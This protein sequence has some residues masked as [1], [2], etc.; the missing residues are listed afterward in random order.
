MLVLSRAILAALLLPAIGSAQTDPDNV[1]QPPSTELARLSP[2][3]GSYSVTSEYVDQEWF[4][5]LD[6]RPA[7][8][9]W[10]VEWEINVHSGPIDRQLRMM[11]TWDRD[12]E[13]Y[14]IWRFETLPAAPAE[15]FEGTGR[16]EGDEF[17]MEWNEPTPWGE[18]G[19]FRNRL[20]L[21]D[22]D[23]LLI[24][25]EGQ[26]EGG[27]VVTVGVTTARRRF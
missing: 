27:E 3:L 2:F 23:T 8:K 20:V 17:V 21:D 24:I 13:A 6:L 1:P 5:S 15:R 19:L 4:G 14:R 10:Y 16:F 22:P 7:V 26:P 11:I 9:G 12:A 25:S 18:P